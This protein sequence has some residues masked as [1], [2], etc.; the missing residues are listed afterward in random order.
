MN[1]KPNLSLENTRPQNAFTGDFSKRKGE[2]R[3]CVKRWK[4]EMEDICPVEVGDGRAN[5]WRLEM[6]ALQK[7]KVELENLQLH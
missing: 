1:Q 5:R 6:E 3:R 2:E 7:Q 4:L